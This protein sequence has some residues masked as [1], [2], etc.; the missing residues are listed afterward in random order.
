MPTRAVGWL[1]RVAVRAGSRVGS[2]VLEVAL[3]L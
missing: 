3:A 1:A 2:R